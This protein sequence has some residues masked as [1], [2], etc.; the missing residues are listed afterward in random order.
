MSLATRATCWLIPSLLPCCPSLSTSTSFPFLSRAGTANFRRLGVAS[1]RSGRSRG[2]RPPLSVSRLELRGQLSQRGEAEGATRS[3]SWHGAN[4][5][6]GSPLAK[7]RG[8]V[9]VRVP[10]PDSQARWRGYRTKDRKLLTIKGMQRMAD[11]DS[12]WDSAIGKRI[13]LRSS[14][15]AWPNGLAKERV[16]GMDEDSRPRLDHDRCAGD[17][18][19]GVVQSRVT[20]CARSVLPRPLLI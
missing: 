8:G 12:G 17:A 15:S 9:P 16:R 4:R 11:P 20:G 19:I 5:G 6:R 18:P 2:F 3:V 14:R 13:V 1:T 7:E 10:H